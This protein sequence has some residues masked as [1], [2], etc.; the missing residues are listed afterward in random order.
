MSATVQFADLDA[1][2]SVLG[3]LLTTAKVIEPVRAES[4]LEAEHFYRDT[5][6]AIYRTICELNDRGS[7]VDP[8]TV[9]DAGGHD[10]E[11][12][13]VLA[14]KVPAPGSASHHARLVIEQSDLRRLHL[15]ALE[16]QRSVSEREGSAAELIGQAK[17]MLDDAAPTGDPYL[18]PEAL[19]EFAYNVANEGR[20]GRTFP[21]PFQRLD[22]LSGGVR[23]GQLVLIAG[24][25]HM[26]KTVMAA[27]LLESVCGAGARACLYFNEMDAEEHIGGWLQRN[28]G[29]PSLEFVQGKLGGD[30]QKRLVSALNKGLP[31]GMCSVAGWDA[32]KIASHIRLHRWDVAVIDILHNIRYED[33]RDLSNAVSAFVEA[34]K[35]AECAVVL[36]AHLNRGRLQGPIRPRPS[37]RDLRGTGDLENKADIV[38]F[39]HREEDPDTHFPG[40]EG[41]VFL[42]KCRGGRLGG[43]EVSFSESRIRFTEIDRRFGAAPEQFAGTI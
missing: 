42:Q 27:Q 12:L 34:A 17:R 40:D 22:R 37:L 23:T 19:R 36:V 4:G 14:A 6:R 35:L 16:L 33:E 24:F 8:I 31:Y 7:P 25:T 29:V 2:E 26:G 3:A 5:H 21:W 38:C 30:H 43:L 9:A 28:W 10:R 15:A 41:E 20:G 18:S 39:V 11:R 1:E 13:M 32:H